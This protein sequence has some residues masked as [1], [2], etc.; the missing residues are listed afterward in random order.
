MADWV[1][2]YKV[3][4]VNPD[5]SAEQIKAARDAIAKKFHPDK[6]QG[7]PPHLRCV[8]EEV[9]KKVSVAYKVLSDPD[10]RRAY[11][12]ERLRRQARS[13]QQAENVAPRQ[14]R[15][16]PPRRTDAKRRPE[17]TRGGQA[18][19]TGW[20]HLHTLW[21]WV[22]DKVAEHAGMIK[23]IAASTVGMA[24]SIWVLTHAHAWSFAWC[25]AL[26]VLIASIPGVLCGA[27]YCLIALFYCLF[28]FLIVVG[29]LLALAL[30]ILI[31]LHFIENPW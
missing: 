9:M 14:A 25:V 1:D 5:A 23:W 8:G 2:Y 11:D 13:G 18:C 29:V 28:A 26:L 24:A 15:E 27:F 4:G 6:L 17:Q 10:T 7:L 3:L 19:A 31:I 21:G 16:Q 30:L 20:L 12:A 22:T